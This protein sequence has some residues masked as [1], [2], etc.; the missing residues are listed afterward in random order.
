M[1]YCLIDTRNTGINKRD[2]NL[3]TTLTF[4]AVCPVKDKKA[5]A[6]NLNPPGEFSQRDDTAVQYTIPSTQSFS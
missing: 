4:K 2:E 6:V 5:P 3:T 1:I